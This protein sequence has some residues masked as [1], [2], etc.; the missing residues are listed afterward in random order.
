VDMI[1][2][3][4]DPN[5]PE[6][7]ERP[8]RL[9]RSIQYRTMRA[10]AVI[11]A[12]ELGASIARA[13]A[14]RGHVLEV[15]LIDQAIGVAAGKALDIQQAGP[16]ERSATRVYAFSEATAAV[17][18]D[19]ILLA[20]PIGSGELQG[21]SG[22]A[23]VRQLAHIDRSAV[24][25][26]AGAR[27]YRLLEQG[28]GELH[29]DRTGFFGSAP[30]ALVSALRAMVAVEA[31]VSPSTVA[32]TALGRIPDRIVVLW[33]DVTVA[34]RPLARVLDAA[35]IGRLVRRAGL[36][37]SLGPF[38]LAAAAARIA[39]AVVTGSRKVFCCT[40]ALDGE[41][42]M[43]RTLSSLP[44][45]IG[46]GGIRRMVAPTLDGREQTLLENAVASS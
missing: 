22:L 7:C 5:D 24:I 45:V 37:R 14:T 25:V 20:D 12:G 46:P 11:G 42:G 23:V 18:A 6:R 17:G 8:E 21:D 9:E 43:R 41:F 35:Q 32:L 29:L 39:E 33:R 10:A 2:S 40:V 31:D 28:V 44:V 1:P 13:L 27:Q 19:V 3:G 4:N 16:I 38:T 26:C 30:E 36:L 15:R 34:G